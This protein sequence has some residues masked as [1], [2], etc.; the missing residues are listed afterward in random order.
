MV[1]IWKYRCP[2]SSTLNARQPSSRLIEICRLIWTG[3]SIARRRQVPGDDERA[4]TRLRASTLL[5]RKLRV[6]SCCQS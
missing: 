5:E 6:W 3:T 1:L 4:V 2:T